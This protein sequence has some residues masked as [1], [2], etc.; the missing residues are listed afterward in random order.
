ML[1]QKLSCQGQST[2]AEDLMLGDRA[3]Q[4]DGEHGHTPGRAVKLSNVIGRSLS[5]R[6]ER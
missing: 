5:T 3:V 6:G 2:V 4:V 1:L